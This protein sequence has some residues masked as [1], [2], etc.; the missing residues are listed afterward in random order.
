M[1]PLQ[2]GFRNWILFNTDL[3]VGS[4]QTIND[5]ENRFEEFTWFAGRLG[6]YSGCTMNS[7]WGNPVPKYPPSVWWCL[8]MNQDY[9]FETSSMETA[10]LFDGNFHNFF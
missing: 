8:K 9:I 7:M 3:E 10:S 5:L 1:C 6:L 4:T 2:D